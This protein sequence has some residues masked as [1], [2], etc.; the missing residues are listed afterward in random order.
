MAKQPNLSSRGGCRAAVAISW[1]TGFR[2]QRDWFGPRPFHEQQASSSWTAREREVIQAIE[3]GYAPKVGCPYPTFPRDGG[4]GYWMCV[5]CT[6]RMTTFRSGDV[7]S[8]EPKQAA[9]N[10]TVFVESVPTCQIRRERRSLRAS[11]ARGICRCGSRK[12]SCRCW[13]PNAGSVIITSANHA[14][15]YAFTRID[16]VDPAL[17]VYRR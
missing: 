3:N 7:C 4:R 14:R 17:C 5:L 9:S 12:I 10:D 2:S 11:K 13:M 6:S 8:F 15:S 16:G 1:R